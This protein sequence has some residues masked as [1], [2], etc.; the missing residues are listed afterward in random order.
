MTRT[1]QRSQRTWVVWS[2]RGVAVALLSLVVY[3]M[4]AAPGRRYLEQ[5][6][7]VGERREQ[8]DEITARNVEMEDRLDRLDDPDEIQRIARR[9]YGLVTEG[10]ESYTIL[11]PST[12][13]L[14]LPDGWPFNTLAEPVRHASSGHD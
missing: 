13:G 7:E 9:D 3:V 5:R 12:A 10:E 6:S 1:E 14:N 4:L 11:P 2:M 8:L